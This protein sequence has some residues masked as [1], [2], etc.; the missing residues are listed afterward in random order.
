MAE[1]S[2]ETQ[3]TK[4]GGVGRGV[5]YL[6]LGN[7]YFIFAGI[8]IQF[9]LPAVL[10]RATF[11]GYTL[12][13]SIASLFNNVFVTGTQQAVSK[14]VAAEPDKA[15][16]VE[17]AGLRMQLRLGVGVALAFVAA[18]PLIAYV[19]HDPDKTAP[20]MLAGLIIGG[21]AF[22]AVFVGVANGLHMFGK[23]AALTVVFA[24]IRAAALIGMAILGA[25]VAGVIGGWVAAVAV[26]LV[27]AIA[28]I[29]LPGRI[30]AG[31][32]LAVSPMIKFFVGVALYLV[33]FNALMFVDT[34]LLKRLMA[35]YFQAHLPELGGGVTQALPWAVGST[36]YRVD[37]SAL[38]DVQVAYYAAVQN[39]AR[40][41]Y[42]IVLAATFVAFPL[43]SRSTFTNDRDRTKLYVG[44]TARYTLIA[45][46]AIGVVMAANPADVLGF[47]YASDFV[48]HGAAALPMLAIGNVAFSIIAIA[49]TIFNGAGR[50]R[51][52]IVLAAITLAIATIGNYFAIPL[53]AGTGHVLEVAATVTGGTM[54]LGAIVSGALLYR[55]FGASLSLVSVL[56]VALAAGAAIG[57]GHVLPLHGKLMTLVE[58][59]AV[60]A[61]YVVVLVATR[62]LGARD[63]AAIKTLRRKR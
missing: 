52:A 40:L 47:M 6:A 54:V 49:G 57:V 14:F 42:Q 53:A 23:Q 56:R 61:T 33:L 34:V 17:H 27:L 59:A 20:L 37:V 12:V 46:A 30:A 36:G 19:L 16:A 48:E 58:A 3:P 60:I 62:E 28:W 39:L 4:P 22:Y 21:Y 41:S 10:P 25:G 8:A 15:R 63:L 18:S 32:R 51:V 43:V 24:T 44:T 29:G 13:N 7:L 1:S 55:Q 11:G 26:I 45:G 31:D 5:L 35:E 2:D 38:A 9:G 50:A